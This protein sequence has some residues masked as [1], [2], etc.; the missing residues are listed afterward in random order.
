MI[1]DQ[2][3]PQVLWNHAASL[4]MSNQANWLLGHP[5]KLLHCET[6]SVK[7]NITSSHPNSLRIGIERRQ[8]QHGL[9]QYLYHRA[10]IL[11]GGGIN[12]L[13]CH[14]PKRC[15]KPSLNDVVTAHLDEFIDLFH[16]R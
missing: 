15:G 5:E 11:M 10:V 8:L 12:L 7:Q 13:S 9:L 2:L 14:L 3:L 4:N 6:R 16:D 1:R